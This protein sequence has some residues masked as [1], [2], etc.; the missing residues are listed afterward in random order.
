M[1]VNGIEF[2]VAEYG[3]ADGPVLVLLHGF[4]ELAFSWRHQIGPL[5]AAGYRLLVPDL[6]GF[7]DS[8]AP[9]AAE[10]LRSSS[11]M[12]NVTAARNA[13]PS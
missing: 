5:A 2:A 7:G 12:N 1:Q 11:S 3:P 9:S 6:R 8:D 10:E 4:P 13:P